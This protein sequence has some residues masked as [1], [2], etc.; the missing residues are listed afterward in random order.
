MIGRFDAVYYEQRGEWCSGQ[1]KKGEG[2]KKKEQIRV[3]GGEAFL[4]LLKLLVKP[5]IMPDNDFV[6]GSFNLK[7]TLGKIKIL[8]PS[9]GTSRQSE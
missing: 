2:E 4:S 9:P 3:W 7:R 8:A 1:R 5:H 6:S